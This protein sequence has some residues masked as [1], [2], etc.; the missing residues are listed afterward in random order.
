M[1]VELVSLKP[2]ELGH[3]RLIQR[4]N[5]LAL[6]DEELL[7]TAHLHSLFAQVILDIDLHALIQLVDLICEGND[8][9][10]I[11]EGSCIG[12]ANS[13]EHTRTYL[14]VQLADIFP[15]LQQLVIGMVEPSDRYRTVVSEH[16]EF[17]IELGLDTFTLLYLL[18]KAFLGDAECLGS[19][20][21]VGQCVLLG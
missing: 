11:D 13:I 9:V 19:R 20:L 10:F 18:S 14:V 7:E 16:F 4:L 17:I 15:V 6:L 3:E 21:K 1:I 5:Q 2:A 8:V 12:L